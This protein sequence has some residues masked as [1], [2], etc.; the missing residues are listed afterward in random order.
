MRIGHRGSGGRGGGEAHAG[1][2]EAAPAGHPA[3]TRPCVL[4]DGGSQEGPEGTSALRNPLLFLLF[5]AGS[6]VAQAG[7]R[8]VSHYAG[9]QLECKNSLYV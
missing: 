8:G 9:L 1:L 5:V 4:T 6:C 2:Q 7:L 3:G